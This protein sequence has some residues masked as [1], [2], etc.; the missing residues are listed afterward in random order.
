M[1]G[2]EAS[3]QAIRQDSVSG[4]LHDHQ[5]RQGPQVCGAFCQFWGRVCLQAL[6]LG[7]GKPH[8]L[9]QCALPQWTAR[10]KSTCRL[11]KRAGN[12]G[13]QAR[14][15]LAAW[16]RAAQARKRE[17]AQGNSAPGRRAQEEPAERF[18]RIAFSSQS[19]PSTGLAAFQQHRPWSQSIGRKKSS[20]YKRKRT[21]ARF[22]AV[23][24]GVR[25][26]RSI[27]FP[28]TGREGW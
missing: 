27:R 21:A 4:E 6:P 7:P 12:E 15:T 23:E 11:L 13:P 5:C 16:V 24:E 17:I 19:L 20:R 26:F 14:T 25:I 1:Q 18:P 9:A 10:A 8:E 22:W 3:K 28:R 2:E